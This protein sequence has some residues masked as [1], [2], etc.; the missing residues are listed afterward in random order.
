MPRSLFT[1]TALANLN[2]L[3]AAKGELIRK[4]LGITQLPVEVNTNKAY[5]HLISALCKMACN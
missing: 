5:E 2:A 3:V 1:E 4:A